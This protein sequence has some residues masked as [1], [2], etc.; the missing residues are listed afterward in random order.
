[1]EKEESKLMTFYYQ[2]IHLLSKFKELSFVAWIS[3]LFVG[4]I[5]YY[6]NTIGYPNSALSLIAF[7]VIC[8]FI[9]RLLAQLVFADKTFKP[10]FNFFPVYQLELIWYAHK[11]KAISSKKFFLG[12]F[13]KAVAYFM[14]L[15]IAN[16][17][18]GV[19]GIPIIENFSNL[20]YGSL[21]LYDS[22]SLLENLSEMGFSQAQGLLRIFKKKSKDFEEQ[23]IG[24]IGNMIE[25]VITP[26]PTSTETQK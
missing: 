19:D 13:I 2:F 3:A 10:K 1:M 7:L 25:D 9:T 21:I 6:G 5:T 16:K 22:I 4:F 23:T 17:I 8:D 12:F 24:E 14:V 11:I 15:G 26:S 18:S 20:I